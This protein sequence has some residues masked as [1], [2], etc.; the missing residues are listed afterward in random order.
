MSLAGLTG[1]RS[2]TDHTSSRWSIDIGREFLN[3]LLKSGNQGRRLKG[4]NPDEV[5]GNSFEHISFRVLIGK[6]KKE[7][8]SN[9]DPLNRTKVLVTV[10]ARP[11]QPVNRYS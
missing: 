6:P 8:I 1:T 11:D 7:S 10:L 4:G 2:R 3:V 5:G 9:G